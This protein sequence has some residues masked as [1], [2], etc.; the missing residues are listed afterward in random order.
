MKEKEETDR[1]EGKGQKWDVNEQ[2]R[3][4]EKNGSEMG[5]REVR[6]REGEVRGREGKGNTCIF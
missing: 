3:E 4:E 6:G 2:R 1:K 5:R